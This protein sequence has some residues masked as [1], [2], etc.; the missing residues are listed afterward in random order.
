LI[1]PADSTPVD[2]QLN[3]EL[4]LNSDAESIRSPNHPASTTVK[5]FNVRDAEHICVVHLLNSNF[6]LGK[7]E[8]LIFDFR[9]NQQGCQAVK[10]SI[11]LYEKRV[12][13][14]SILQVFLSIKLIVS[15]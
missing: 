9:K 14:P 10:A 1:Y 5:S 8:M 6:A 7:E 15:S 13:D 4:S 12:L 11:M 2:G 3:N